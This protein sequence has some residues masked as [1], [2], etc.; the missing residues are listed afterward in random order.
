M[1]SHMYSKLMCI[2]TYGIETI[3]YKLFLCTKK[4]HM[5]VILAEHKEPWAS[6]L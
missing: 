5:Y 4:Y 1:N 3:M 6:C 2:C